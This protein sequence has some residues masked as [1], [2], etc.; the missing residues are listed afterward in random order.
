MSES[1]PFVGPD[2]F[3]AKAISRYRAFIGISHDREFVA[4]REGLGRNKTQFHIFSRIEMGKARGPGFPRT[5]PSQKQLAALFPRQAVLREK[6]MLDA[7]A[8]GFRN[9]NEDC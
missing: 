9:V 5:L 8:A 2:S 4:R 7:L 3:L 6:D 1:E